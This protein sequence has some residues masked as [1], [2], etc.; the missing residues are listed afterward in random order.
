VDAGGGGGGGL[1]AV[2]ALSLAQ[3]EQQPPAGQSEQQQQQQLPE[4]PQAI[5]QQQQPQQQHQPPPLDPAALHQLRAARAAQAASYQLQG[6]PLQAACCCLSVDDVAGAV[7]ALLRGNEPEQA[8]ALALALGGPAGLPAEVVARALCAL[9]DKCEAGGG[10]GGG[11]AAAALARLPEGWR[12][13]ERVE[14]LGARLGAGLGA[15][16]RDGVYGGLGLR[17]G[18][19]YGG[20]A[21]ARGE[22]EEAAR[23]GG[24]CGVGRGGCCG[25]GKRVLWGGAG[26]VGLVGPALVASSLATHALCCT[27]PLPPQ[28]NAR[29]CWVAPQVPA[30]GRPPC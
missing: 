16:E 18:G 20:A 5:Q 7:L 27:A 9:A 3:P 24:C 30:A 23:W 13:E 22:G 25:V 29:R 12:R 19:W 6:L 17:P 11:S 14:L 4:Q 10:G 21:A 26:F 8:A 1:P 28:K 2:Q 15:E